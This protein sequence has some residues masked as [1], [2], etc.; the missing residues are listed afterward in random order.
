MADVAGFLQATAV[1]YC[2]YMVVP[3]ANLGWVRL[4]RLGQI[5]ISGTATSPRQV[6]QVLKQTSFSGG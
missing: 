6:P 3:F 2:V 4:L 1:G 5:A